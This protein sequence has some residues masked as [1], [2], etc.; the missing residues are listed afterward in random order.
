MSE[1]GWLWLYGVGYL[2]V[3]L[4]FSAWIFTRRDLV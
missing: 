1:V 3:L 4:F 2:G